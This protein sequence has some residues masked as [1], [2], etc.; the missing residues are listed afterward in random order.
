MRGSVSFA[1]FFSTKHKDEVS[2]L[3]SVDDWC[4]NQLFY[5]GKAVSWPAFDGLDFI[6]V[7]EETADEEIEEEEPVADLPSS[8]R[9]PKPGKWWQRALA[10]C[11]CC[12]EVD[13]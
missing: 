11:C 6:P 8:S 4:P 10:F 13:F 3:V 1:S 12:Y 5:M 9:P 7:S 2:M